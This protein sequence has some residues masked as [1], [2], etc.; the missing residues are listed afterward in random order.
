MSQSLRPSVQST[1]GFPLVRL[2][3]LSGGLPVEVCLI[4]QLSP[5]AGDQLCALA[6][7]QQRG[8]GSFVDALDEPSAKLFGVDIP[9]G[10]ATSLYSFSVGQ[11][12]HPFHRH[13]GHRMFTAVSGSDGAQLRFSTIDDTSLLSDPSVFLDSLRVVNIPPD[14]LFSVRFGG[15]TWHQFAHRNPDSP[16][17][18]FFALSCHTDELGGINDQEL[19]EAIRQDAADIPTLTDVL[20]GPVRDLLDAT[21]FHTLPLSTTTL[22][23]S[24]APDSWAHRLCAAVRRP[25]GAI[26]SRLCAPRAATGYI[27]PGPHLAAVP[28]DRVAPDSLLAAQFSEGF[29]HEDVVEVLLPPLASHAQAT[30]VLSAV[31]DGFLDNRPEGVA[32]LMKLRNVAVRPLRLRT[33]PLGCPVS[34]LL[35]DDRSCVYAGRFPV[36]DQRVSLD[37]QHAQ[38][39]LGADDRHLVFRS[40]VS[41]EHTPQGFRVT[42]GTRVRC[43]NTF[44]R[45]Y[46][47]LIDRTHRRYVAP[48]LLEMA[49]AHAMKSSQEAEG[50]A[51]DV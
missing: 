2:P 6:N 18:V 42:L 7:Q 16:H 28:T 51:L 27:A 46:M 11:G 22:S 13:A 50:V 34:S 15:G 25:A 36:L 49:V 39:L 21:P 5:G 24:A 38:V 44:G 48:L 37:R 14:S 8:H 12:G 3:S 47:A 45:V 9:K 23:L 4:A 26:K 33:S 32:W 35:S 30:T 43:L 29:H 1:P 31:L 17:P 10:D 19:A 20:P 40:C 41:V